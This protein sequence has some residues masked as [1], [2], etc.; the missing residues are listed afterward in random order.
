MAT[1]S[2]DEDSVGILGLA[3]SVIAGAVVSGIAIA[4]GEAIASPPGSG[5]FDVYPLLYFMGGVI[6]SVPLSMVG[7][8]VWKT[9][10]RRNHSGLFSVP[11]FFVPMAALITGVMI[12]SMSA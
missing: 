8:G 11:C 1:P 3:G 9:I 6:Y 4:F 2:A 7:I 5:E 12:P 10:S